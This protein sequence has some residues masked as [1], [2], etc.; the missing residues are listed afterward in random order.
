MLPIFRRAIFITVTSLTLF[1]NELLS[2]AIVNAIVVLARAIRVSLALVSVLHATVIA[3]A[4]D[5]ESRVWLHGC[6]VVPGSI[7]VTIGCT[8]MMPE[9]GS[10]SALFAIFDLLIVIALF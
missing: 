9:F 4:I 2:I 7:R 1:S 10:F 8:L 5:D 6:L 3:L